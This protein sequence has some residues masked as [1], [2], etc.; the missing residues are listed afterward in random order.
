MSLALISSLAVLHSAAPAPVQTLLDSVQFTKKTN[1]NK[2]AD[3]IYGIQ[4]FANRSSKVNVSTGSGILTAD[5]KLASDGNQ[6]YTANA[7]V[8]IPLS[9]DWAEHDLSDLASINFKYRL[10]A[11]ISDG[12]NVLLGSGVYSPTS[13]SQGVIYQSQIRGAAALSASK[14]WKTADLSI[15][16]FATPAWWTAPVDFPTLEQVL[17]RMNSVHLQPQSLYSKAGTQSG[18]A[19]TKCVGPVTPA[20][21]AEFRDFKLVRRQAQQLSGQFEIA[22]SDTASINSIYGIQPYSNN[23]STVALSVG[24]GVLKSDFNLSSDGTQGYTAIAGVLVPIRP[25]WETVDLRG[26]TSI[27]FEYRNDQKISDGIYVALGSSSYLLDWVAQGTVY[28]GEIRGATALAGGTSWKTATLDLGDFATPAWWTAPMDF[29]SIDSVLS[30]AKNLDIR[31]SSIYSLNGTMSDGTPCTRCVG[32]VTPKV[33]LELRSIKLIGNGTLPTVGQGVVKSAGVPVVSPEFAGIEK[34][35]SAS[36]AISWQSGAL[37]LQ[38]P[39]QWTSVQITTLSGR[40]LRTL[41]P[42]AQMSVDLPT[43]SYLAILSGHEGVRT[44]LPIQIMR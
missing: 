10:D 4:T 9:S 7:G 24:S 8:M 38:D 43:G 31:V 1:N 18:M 37:S 33:S 16:D 39:S 19:C 17:K 23:A 40:Q 35:A 22:A 3:R 14:T 26:L 2:A 21:T 41:E 27:Q 12:L 30:Q 6:G 36:R 29:P 32:P 20:V 13:V 15:D 28:Q 34:A 11:K 42:A 44:A 25:T 5:I